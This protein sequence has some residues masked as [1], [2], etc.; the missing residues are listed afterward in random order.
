MAVR[1][2]ALACPSWGLGS[3]AERSVREGER[4][5]EAAVSEY[6][7]RMAVLPLPLDDAPGRNSLRGYIEKNAIALLSNF[8]RPAIDRSSA[9]WLGHCC[10][11]ERVR[12]SGLWNSNH[13]DEEYDPEF[14]SVLEHS[15]EVC[16]YGEEH[17][18]TADPSCAS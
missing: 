11:R 14:L 4:S 12:L 18:R 16:S 1:S 5:L 6:L 13:V 2:P 15:V 17:Q 7:G 10:P 9:N 3:S 8:E